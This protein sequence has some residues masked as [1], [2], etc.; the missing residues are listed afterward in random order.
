MTIR[1]GSTF[2]M[3]RK[4]DVQARL[5]TL[6]P[7][8]RALSRPA[9]SRSSGPVPGTR[10]LPRTWCPIRCS[11]LRPISRFRPVRF[12]TQEPLQQGGA[13]LPHR[14]PRNTR[15]TVGSTSSICIAPRGSL[16]SRQKASVEWIYPDADEIKGLL[17]KCVAL[18]CVPIL[19]A[20]RFPRAT[21][22]VLGECGVVLHQTL[23]Q[24][25]HVTDRGLADRAKRQD[26]LGFNDIRV[27]DEP[28]ARLLSFIG[29]SLPEQLPDARTRFD[30]YRG[31]LADYAD[32]EITTESS[33]DVC[34]VELLA[35]KKLIGKTMT[36]TIPTTIAADSFRSPAPS[37]RRYP[38]DAGR[39]FEGDAA[40]RGQ[41]ACGYLEHGA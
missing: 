12:K 4:Q 5:A 41:L 37:H 36:K 2:P 29:T 26:S 35:R 16:V 17:V 34:G 1:R 8:L 38:F 40:E 3:P 10:H 9:V 31:L 30:K 22:D 6:E 32:G 20:R 39:L 28:D 7:F 24:L 13:A 33:P 25:F 14:G 18:D 15:G 27:G 19:V 11:L 23:N 21:F